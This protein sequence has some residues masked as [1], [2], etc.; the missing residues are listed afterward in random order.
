[1]GCAD[2]LAQVVVEPGAVGDETG[3][4]PELRRVDR[5]HLGGVEAVQ[6]RLDQVVV[7]GAGIVTVGVHIV[8]V[9][10]PT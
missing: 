2:G 4:V 10:P 3:D 8:K 6:H 7:G 9:L 5:G 1:M